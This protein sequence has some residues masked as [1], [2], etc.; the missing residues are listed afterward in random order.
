MGRAGPRPMRCGLYMGRSAEPMR[1]PT[2]FHRPARA[3]AH[4]M[5]CTAVAAIICAMTK[6]TLPM[7]WPT[8][9]GGSA[10]AA[11]HHMLCAASTMTTSTSA[12]PMRGKQ[13]TFSGQDTGRPACNLC[14][15]KAAEERFT[16]C[17]AAKNSSNNRRGKQWIRYSR[18]AYRTKT[19]DALQIRRISAY[20]AQPAVAAAS[21]RVNFTP[22]RTQAEPNNKLP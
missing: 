19:G 7:R 3:A 10:R 17:F 2:S 5:W 14:K 18:Y 1:R 8:R 21:T 12:L 9:F 4:E 22:D 13:P 20:Q 15:I 16:V 11:A 6:S